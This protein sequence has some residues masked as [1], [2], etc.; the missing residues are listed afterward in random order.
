[1]VGP[2]YELPNQ[3][4]AGDECFSN[5]DSPPVTARNSDQQINFTPEIPNIILEGNTK[6]LEE[7]GARP[8]KFELDPNA[9]SSHM[10]NDFPLIRLAEMYMIKAEALTAMNGGPTAE[11]RQAFNM[12]RTRTGAE[13]LSGTPSESEMY[14]LILQER[15]FE[16]HFEMHRRQDQI[17]YEFAHG[18]DRSDE[19]YAPS[20]T[21]PWRFKDPSS[22]QYAIFPIPEEQIS[23]NPKLEQYDEY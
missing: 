1:M 5:P 17:R 16:F 12:V 7:P 8:L 3:D 19:P 10:G 2:Q 18:M 6:A 11:A 4:C 15:G 9:A 20:F 21:G 22:V 13:G 23:V 14:E